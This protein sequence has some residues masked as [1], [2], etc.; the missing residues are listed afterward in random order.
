[1]DGSIR[2]GTEIDTKTFDSQIDYIEQRMAD[3]EAKL[4]EA[5]MGFEV[6]DT[7]KL[8]ATYERLA[9]Q[10]T[11]LRKKRDDLNDTGMTMGTQGLNKG[12]EGLIKSAKRFTLSLLSIR[13]VYG[14]LS[15]ASSS[16]LSTDEKSTKQIEANWVGLGAIFEPIINLIVNMMK[17]AVTSIL[18]FMS[19]LTG[20]DY[21]AKANAAALKKQANATKGLTKEQDKYNASFDEMNVLRDNSSGADTGGIDTSVLF[22]I[23][24]LSSSTLSTIEKLGQALKPVY[25]IIKDIIKYCLQNPGVILAML[26][27]TALVGTIAKIIG[28]AGAG[29]AVGTGLAGIL[30]VLLAIAAIGVITISIITIYKSVKEAKKQ[31]DSSTESIEGYTESIKENGEEATKTAASTEK[32]TEKQ[33]GV[34][35]GFMQSADNAKRDTEELLNNR[36][37]MMKTAPFLYK[38][39]GAF[40]NNSAAIKN[41]L[42]SLYQDTQVL[43]EFAKSGQLTDDEIKRVKG[44]MEFFTTAVETNGTSVEDQMEKFGLNREE[45]EKLVDQY[46]LVKGQLDKLNKSTETSTTDVN[47]LNSS[48]DNLKKNK[49]LTLNVNA[50]TTPAKSTLN[51]FFQTLGNTFGKIGIF[52]TISRVAKSLFMATGGIVNNPGRGVPVS[53]NVFA[54]EAGREG[55]IPL[56]DSQAMQ[57]LGQEIGKWITINANITNSMNGR[58]ISKELQKIQNDSNFASNR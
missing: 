1:M 33:L 21:I 23:K 53:S 25:E 52:P 56:T 20:T 30:G 11:V 44:S 12:F 49:D 54:G 27:G 6:G 17:K 55:V 26:G 41:N 57:Q 51:G 42:E 18:Y 38:M 47:N 13:G 50:D 43:N 5:D 32:F 45:A 46:Y 3:I 15:K 8:E 19:V 14:I 4:K 37:E 36:V 31:I 22:D 39:T 7:Q 34:A 40:D 58:V 2:I 35:K 24:D 28:F 48:M 9:N 29:T 16:Y 10:L